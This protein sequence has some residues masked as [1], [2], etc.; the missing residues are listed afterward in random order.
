MDKILQDYG[1]DGR[2]LTWEQL[3]FEADIE[4]ISGRTIRRHMHTIHY[5]KCLACK[6]GWIS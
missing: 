3:T 1:M 6:R 4:D 2:I 5:R